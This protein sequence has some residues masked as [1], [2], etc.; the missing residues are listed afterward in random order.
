MSRRLPAWLTKRFIQEQEQKQVN[1]LLQENSLNTV[2]KSAQCPNKGECFSRGTATFMILGDTCTRNCHFC[3]VD[4][5]SPAIKNMNKEIEGI[6]QTISKLELNYVVITSVTRDDIVDKGVRY[7][8]R[9]ANA[10]KNKF[11]DIKVELLTPDFLGKDYLLKS[12]A[13]AKFDVFNHNLETVPDLYDD[14]RPGADY[15]RSL[16]VLEIMSRSDSELAIKSGLMLGLGETENQLFNVMEDLL[17]VGCEILT[18]GQYLQPSSEHYP[19]KEFISPDK[20]A[21]CRH[22]A[23]DMGF[24]AVMAGPFVRSSYQAKETYQKAKKSLN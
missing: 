4:Y 17:G 19:V 8:I 7:F 22:R 20:F 10:V 13:K 5:G 14:I 16:K 3:A 12:L 6:L 11:S 18:L 2:C 1:K 15:E 9:V 23:L 21:K 24:K